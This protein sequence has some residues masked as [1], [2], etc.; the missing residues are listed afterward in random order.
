MRRPLVIGGTLFIGKELVRRLLERGDRVTILHRG[1]SRLPDGVDEIACD[2]NDEAAVRG[3]LR[4]RGF[5]VAFDNVYDWERG[6]TAEQVRAAAEA[7]A[8]GI[9]RYVFL[10]SVAA[11]GEGADHTEEDP[12]ALG[13]ENP[14]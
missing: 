1:K 5:D 4:G 10:S 8:G 3:A 11:Y 2:R 7:C 13:H 14:Y 9:Q 6:T 12:L